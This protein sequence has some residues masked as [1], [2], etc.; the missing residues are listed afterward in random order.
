MDDSSMRVS[1]VDVVAHLIA[2]EP[3]IQQIKLIRYR[4]ARTFRATLKGRCASFDATLKRRLRHG[5]KN[6]QSV[7]LERRNATVEALGRA[8]V[9]TA[10]GTALAVASRV[11]L[12][13][14]REGHLPLLDLQCRPTATNL[15]H[16]LHAMRRILPEGGVVLNSGRS[17]HYYG[18][19][20]LTP[21]EWRQFLGRCLLLEP[22]VDVRNLGHCLIDG[23]SALRLSPNPRGEP[24]FVVGTVGPQ[25]SAVT[26]S[27]GKHPLLRRNGR[28][29]RCARNERIEADIREWHRA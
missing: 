22:L 24:P 8:M 12:S 5:G 1:A 25:L 4:P 19:H 21:S 2:R 20:L 3:R 16:I 17:F 14:G 27:R 23:E 28:G 7:R 29:G 9:A 13:R 10:R 11:S 15:R 26:W 6:I 18:R